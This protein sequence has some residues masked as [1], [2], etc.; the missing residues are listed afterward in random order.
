MTDT[1]AIESLVTESLLTES[2]LT[3][4]LLTE[5]R[6]TEFQLG[7]KMTKSLPIKN[8]TKPLD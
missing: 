7:I 3:E 1:Q 5:S 6:V 2:L 8:V 4:Y